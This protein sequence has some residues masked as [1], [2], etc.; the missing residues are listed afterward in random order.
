LEIEDVAEDEAI[1]FP[2][3]LNVIEEVT[4][5]PTYYNSNISKRK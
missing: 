4:D 5:N 2:P 3:F 1:T